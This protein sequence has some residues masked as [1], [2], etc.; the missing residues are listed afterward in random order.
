MEL[1]DDQVTTALYDGPE[2]WQ[3]VM[4][5]DGTGSVCWFDADADAN[6]EVKVFGPQPLWIDEDI[7][8]KVVLQVLGSSTADTQEAVDI[9]ANNLLHRAIAILLDDPSVGLIDDTIQEF[10]ALPVS[11]TYTSGVT[12]SGAHA[13]RFTLSIQVMSRLKLELPA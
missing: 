11:W 12:A 13:A 7:T 2:N 10:S 9:T 8:C 5:D 3:D 1:L 6:F 4:G